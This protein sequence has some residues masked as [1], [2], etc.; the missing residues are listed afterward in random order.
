[1]I[2]L[3]IYFEDLKDPDKAEE[4]LNEAIEKF[5]EEKIFLNYQSNLQMEKG[6]VAIAAD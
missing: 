1:M 2:I 4:I 5:P 3:K 6:K